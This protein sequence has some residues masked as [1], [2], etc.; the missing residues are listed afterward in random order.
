[1]TGLPVVTV[2]PSA[3][4]TTSLNVTLFPEAASSFS[5]ARVSPGLTRYC[6]PPERII[7]YAM[8][9]VQFGKAQKLPQRIGNDNF[10]FAS[11][12]ALEGG[13]QGRAGSPPFD[14]AASGMC[15]PPA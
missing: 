11:I 5:T 6:L 3:R 7:A 13:P 2:S 1:M 4:K 9:R 10:F 12:R 15:A 8:L 14:P